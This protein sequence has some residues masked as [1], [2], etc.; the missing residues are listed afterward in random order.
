MVTAG[1]PSRAAIVSAAST[2]RARSSRAACSLTVP[3]PCRGILTGRDGDV[4]TVYK[5]PRGCVGSR[6]MSHRSR[7]PLR[8]RGARP[9]PR[10]LALA[11]GADRG[12]D[13]PRRGGRADRERALHHVLRRGDRPGAGGR[14]A[15]RRQGRR[16]R[17]RSRASASAS[18][19]RCR[20]RASRAR[21]GS[22][23]YKDHVRGRDRPGRAAPD[24]RRRDPPRPHDGAGVLVRRVH[25]LRSCGASRAT[26][27]T[28]SSASAARPAAPARRSPPARP[29]SPPAPTSA[30]RSASRRPGTASS[31]SSRRTAACRR[32]RRSTS[33][34]T[35][36][37]GRWRAPS[38]T[39]A[40]FENVIA[41]PHPA[42]PGRDRA[43]ATSCR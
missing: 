29:R 5:R 6:A 31:G 35:A 41:G 37:P 33:T 39:C 40:L 12:A 2:M 7:L 26:R 24:R 34:T 10:P 9:V 17:G 28:R 13:R 43:E 11:R 30:A 42:R 36:T 8:D 14:E 18:R 15:L 22:L 32:C 25:A 1:A 4:N 3:I 21:M 23:R 16:S 38:P 19:T 20:S 27:G